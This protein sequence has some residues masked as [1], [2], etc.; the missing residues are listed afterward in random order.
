MAKVRMLATGGTIAS[1]RVGSRHLAT[2]PGDELLARATVPAD[3]EVSVIDAARVGSFAWTWP[4]LVALVREV[5]AALA[6]GV[7]AVLVTHGTDTMEEVA[8]LVSLV[9]DDPRPVVFTGAQRPFD[10]PASDG[11]VNVADA[12]VTAVSPHARDRGVLVAFDGQVFAA[13]GVTKSD[14]LRSAPFEAPGRGP[15]LRVAGGAVLALTPTRRPPVFPVHLTDGTPPRVDVV[16]MYVGVD[17]A[18]IRSAIAAGAAGIVLA[19]FGAGNAN[20]TIVEAA[21]DAVAS[22]IPVLVCSRAQA[23]PVLPLYGGGGGADL[24]DADVI[25]GADLSPW[26]GRMLLT[27]ALIADPTAPGTLVADWLGAADR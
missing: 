14:T 27:V 7:D 16:P 20:P 6:E 15:Q 10:H 23:G 8:F 19:A 17:D 3:C 1:R 5:D 24:A 2:V 13:R 18:P 12:L 22:G 4:D 11:P 9:H 21:R 25:F 26:Q